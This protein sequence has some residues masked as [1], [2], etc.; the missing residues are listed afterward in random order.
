MCC[1]VSGMNCHNLRVVFQLFMKVF[2]SEA[3]AQTTSRHCVTL[4]MAPQD[5]G[6]VSLFDT[7]QVKS[8]KPLRSLP[9]DARCLVA[10]AFSS[11]LAKSASPTFH[12]AV[13]QNKSDSSLHG[14]IKY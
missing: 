3:E 2:T 1:Q 12:S 6:K 7:V 10:C 4:L 9:R 13:P 14:A 8:G 5:L 11:Q